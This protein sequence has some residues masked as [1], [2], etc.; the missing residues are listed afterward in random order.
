MRRLTVPPS[1]VNFTELP[2]MFTNTCCRRMGSPT[3]CSC[4]IS[5]I[6]T[7]KFSFLSLTCGVMIE[8]RL[9][10]VSGRSKSSSD[11]PKL[12]LSI[13]AISST[14]LIRPS[15]CRLEAVIFVRQSF[16]RSGS[17]KYIEAMAVSPIMEF[18]GVRMSWL[19]E[20]RKSVFARLARS[21][22]QKASSR[23]MRFAISR[24]FTSVTS[25]TDRSTLVTCFAA[26]R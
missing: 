14:S 4:W 13:F 11:N 26:S 21:A 6:S 19:M 24:S 23:A 7:F 8:S 22:S 17:S 20:L 2:M 3:T 9:S 18:I 15:K 5:A 10:T 12:P 1:G 25:C 16:T